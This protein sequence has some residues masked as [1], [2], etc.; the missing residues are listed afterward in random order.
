MDYYQQTKSTQN[1]DGIL[2][3]FITF[4]L[5]P[6]GIRTSDGGS[7]LDGLKTAVTRTIN[8]QARKVSNSSQFKLIL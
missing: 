5:I 2:F 7:H 4:R 6:L 3:Y 1:D 8:A